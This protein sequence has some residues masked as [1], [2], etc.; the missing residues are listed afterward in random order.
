MTFKNKP[1]ILAE[2]AAK[3]YPIFHAAAIGP[4][5]D[6][7]SVTH[8]AFCPAE[9]LSAAEHGDTSWRMIHPCGRAIPARCC[10]LSEPSMSSCATN[11]WHR[12]CGVTRLLILISLAGPFTSR[13]ILLHACDAAALYRFPDQPRY[14]SPGPRTPSLF[15]C[16]RNICS[17]NSYDL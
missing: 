8:L 13:S 11:E 12:I 15:F 16:F 4:R 3:I 10:C 9:P 7:C 1:E 2:S 6:N 17:E 5:A 14:H